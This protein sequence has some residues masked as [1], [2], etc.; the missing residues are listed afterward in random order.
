MSRFFTLAVSTL[1]CVVAGCNDDGGGDTATCGDEVCDLGEEGVCTDCSE[2]GNDICEL[3]EP[4]ACADCSVC[5]NGLCE[6]GEDGDGETGASCADCAECGNGAC[7]QGEDAT[8]CA[9]CAECGN[10]AC[11]AGEAASC[12]DD[13]GDCGNAICE[14]GET[15]ATCA[16][17]AVCGN[18]NCDLGEDAATCADC[19]VCGNA[20]CEAGEAETC[21]TDG[22]SA[23]LIVQNNSSYTIYNLY[24]RT[25]D[26]ATWG[27]D[28]TGAAFISPSNSFTVSAIPP[29]CYFFRASTSGDAMYWQTPSGIELAPLQTYTWTLV[30]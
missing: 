30:N 19:A 17:C 3:G 29:G 13:C 24:V 14:P 9:D 22:C 11:D 21:P 2:C 1:L 26:A 6:F 20:V 25:C 4:G 7:D 27:V 18:D 15:G 23:T 16:D 28:L 12:P 5:G 10:A 8:T